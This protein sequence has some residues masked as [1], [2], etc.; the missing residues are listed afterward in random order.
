MACAPE[1][2]VVHRPEHDPAEALLG[3]EDGLVLHRVHVVVP[4][5]EALLRVGVGAD[6]AR[7]GP[8]NR[9]ALVVDALAD[10]GEEEK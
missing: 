4:D 6:G 8:L 3:D 7:V 9:P 1:V 10:L 2:V 5:P